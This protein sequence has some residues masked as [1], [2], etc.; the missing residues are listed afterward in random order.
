MIYTAANSSEFEQKPEI[1]HCVVTLY[2]K[3]YTRNIVT[4][5]NRTLQPFSNQLL[6]VED[7]H[8]EPH[9]L[10][11]A[12]EG[13][14]TFADNASYVMDPFSYASLVYYLADALNA[15]VF[16]TSSSNREREPYARLGPIIYNSGSVADSFSHMATSI[17]NQIRSGAK[18]THVRG[19]TIRTETF[20]HV[21]WP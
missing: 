21:R 2:E 7:I 5:S 11:T 18:G 15:T 16:G 19:L 6:K 9:R 3:L 17:T 20:I 13:T 1:T 4:S 10:I 8:T 14:K 12:A